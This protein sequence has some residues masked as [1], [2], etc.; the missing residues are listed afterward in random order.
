MKSISW[1]RLSFSGRRNAFPCGEFA[2]GIG[3]GQRFVR[4]TFEAGAIADLR[5]WSSR[6]LKCWSGGA[7]YREPREQTEGQAENDMSPD[8]H[9]TRIQPG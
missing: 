2:G 1:R 4:V 9:A 7:D 8:P 5:S 3:F 6:V